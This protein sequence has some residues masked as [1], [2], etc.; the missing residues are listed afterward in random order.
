VIRDDDNLSPVRDVLVE[1]GDRWWSI[2]ALQRDL[3][4][5][6]WAAL[7]ECVASLQEQGYVEDN[8]DPGQSRL[9]RRTGKIAVAR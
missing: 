1:M 2:P 7:A 9:Y 3:G 5:P 4:L 8:D 6:Q